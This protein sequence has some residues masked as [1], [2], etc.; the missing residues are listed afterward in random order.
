MDA[1]QG[2]ELLTYKLTL[3][4]LTITACCVHAADMPRTKQFENSIGMTCRLTTDAEYMARQ[5]VGL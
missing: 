5:I 3:L 4:T 2:A 1:I